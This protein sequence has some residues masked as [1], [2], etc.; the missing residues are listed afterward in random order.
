MV[1]SDGRRFALPLAPGSELFRHEE[2]RTRRVERWDVVESRG[3]E[4]RLVHLDRW[5]GAAAAGGPRHVVVAPV[6]DERHGI[7]VREV[8]GREERGITPLGAS[9]RGLAGSSGATVLPDGCIA[10]ILDFT[11]MGAA[12]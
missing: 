10:L 3:T 4:L 7:V 11:G 6:G 8:I 12:A 2:A 5:L 1:R 9:L